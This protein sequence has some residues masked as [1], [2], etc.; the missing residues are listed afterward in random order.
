M[1]YGSGVADTTMI[2]GQLETPLRE[3][4]ARKNVVSPENA[5]KTN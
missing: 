3:F 2:K 1:E 5:V 4:S